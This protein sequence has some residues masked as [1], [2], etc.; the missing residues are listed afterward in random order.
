MT[1]ATSTPKTYPITTHLELP[2]SVMSRTSRALTVRGRH[3]LGLRCRNTGPWRVLGVDRCIATHGVC[4]DIRTIGSGVP[5]K[6]LSECIFEFLGPEVAK[7]IKAE[8]GS[9]LISAQ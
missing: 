7:Q 3:F 9:M 5:T 6:E 4:K 1:S 8:M 2:W